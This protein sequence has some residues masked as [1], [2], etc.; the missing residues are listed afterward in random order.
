MQYSDEKSFIEDQLASFQTAI[1][2]I[3]SQKKKYKLNTPE[4]FRGDKDKVLEAMN[5][6]IS[7]LKAKLEA[8]KRAHPDEVLI[9]DNSKDDQ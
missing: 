8:Y 7:F 6:S 4:D 1:K 2:I 9:E 3:K 5:A